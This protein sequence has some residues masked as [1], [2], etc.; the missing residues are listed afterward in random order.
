MRLWRLS[1][2]QFA[3]AMDGGYGLL[4]DGR[5]NATGRP[6]TYAATSPAL[7]VLEK[8]V[9]VEDPRLLPPLAL[10][11]YD[12]PDTTAAERRDIEDLP[13]DWRDRETFTQQMGMAWLDGLSSALLFVP[14]A[15][16][17]VV[18]GPDRNALINPR[19]PEAGR[20]SI[21]R[22][23][24]FALDTRVLRNRQARP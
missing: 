6:V 13:A 9:H 5:W 23:E 7:C 19:H 11:A 15:I 3:E 18:G 21:A 2:I 22:A 14:S 24:P 17:P 10:V 20:I 12:I 16:V 4:F 1:T 8:L